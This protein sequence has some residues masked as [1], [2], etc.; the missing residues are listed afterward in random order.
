MISTS[1]IIAIDNPKGGVGKTMTTIN[2]SVLATTG[3]N[4]LLIDLD[5]QGNTSTGFGVSQQD[6]KNN[7]YQALIGEI[8][9]NQ[10]IITTQVPNFKYYYC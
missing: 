4:I 1:Q 6:R 2:L 3:A 10:C 8:S 7:I 9:I 5:L